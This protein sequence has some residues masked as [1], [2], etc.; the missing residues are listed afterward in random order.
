MINIDFLAYFLIFN[1]W[2]HKATINL[3]NLVIFPLLLIRE[4]ILSLVAFE[5]LALEHFCYIIMLFVLGSFIFSL[6]CFFHH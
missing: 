3:I 2:Q 5:L 4:S 6:I 1:V